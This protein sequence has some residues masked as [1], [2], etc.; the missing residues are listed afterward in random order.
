MTHLRRLR[1]KGLIQRLPKS[2]RCGFT[3][4]GRR[5]ALFLTKLYVPLVRPTLDRM[6]PQ[7]PDDGPDPLRRAWKGCESAFEH[8]AQEAR[9]AA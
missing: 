8:S 7:L 5:A 2:H 9:I 3:A 1:L 6:E 4:A